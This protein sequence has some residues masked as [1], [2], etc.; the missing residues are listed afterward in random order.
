MRLFAFLV[1]CLM[2]FLAGHI[3]N[4][5]I[6]FLFLEWFDSHALA[7]IGFGL[8]FGP[9]IILGWFAG[10]YCDRYSP[11]K[12]ILIAQNFFFISLLLLFTALASVKGEPALTQKVLLLSAALFAGIGW[13]FVAPARFACLV[14]YVKNKNITGATIILNLMVMMGFGLA[15]M[16]LKQIKFHYDWT[17]VFMVATTLF[18]ISSA[19]LIPL[20]FKYKNQAT[21]YS[22]KQNIHHSVKEILA[23]LTIVKQN[24]YLWQLLLLAMIAYLLMGP[25][26]VILPTIAKLNLHL[27][28]TNQGNFLSLVAFSLIVGG[29]LAMWTRTKG[30]LGIQL[31]LAIFI[32]G[33][34][35]GLLGQISQLKTAVFVLVFAATCGGI[36]IS[37][38]VAGL[39]RFSPDEHRGRIMSFYT[40][41]SQF[42]PAMAGIISG[43]LAQILTP[44]TALA[45]IG[46]V[47]GVSILISL[48][49]LTH[50][51]QLNVFELNTEVKQA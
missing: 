14:F 27:N 34:G 29:L 30:K 42:I 22:F 25:M 47:I 8:C 35:I 2:A 28:E 38:I 50:I 20:T 17:M 31:L 39:Q 37:L 19:I 3:I 16:L 32:A 26:Q 23:S 15:P 13:S 4:Y 11:R 10:V 51:R 9:P 46:G 33:T 7:G 36:A 43:M 24:P 48:L 1:S 44:A 12:V 21:K 18:L 45:I 5:S 49:L 40:I 41:I 6:I